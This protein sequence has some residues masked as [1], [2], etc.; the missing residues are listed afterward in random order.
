MRLQQFPK[1]RMSGSARMCLG[2]E[3]DAAGPAC[4]KARSRNLVYVAAVVRSQSTTLTSDVDPGGVVGWH[5]ATGQW[6]SDKLDICHRKLN[7]VGVVVVVVFLLAY[8]ELTTSD[9]TGC[10]QKVN[11]HRIISKSY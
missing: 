7:A 3:F 11:H 8:I 4:E 6:R 10:P 5:E 2:I 1:T 9:C